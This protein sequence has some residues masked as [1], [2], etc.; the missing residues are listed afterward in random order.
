MEEVLFQEICIGQRFSVCIVHEKLLVC[1]KVY[2]RMR[3]LLKNDKINFSVSCSC[4]D[5]DTDTW[6]CAF[7]VTY[8]GLVAPLGSPPRDSR[9]PFRD[10]V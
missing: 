7:F 10:L 1:R 2:R 8:S 6:H 3:Y 9:L 5:L 4:F